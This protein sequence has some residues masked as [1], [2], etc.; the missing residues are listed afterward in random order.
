MSEV[1]VR[2]RQRRVALDPTPQEVASAQAEVKEGF[3][4]V[5]RVAYGQE[6]ETL[7]KV[8][9]PLFGTQSA[10]VRVSAGATR[11]L[12]DYNSARV[13]VMIELPCYPEESEMRRAYEFAST[14]LDELV[15]IELE[16]AGVPVG[17]E[18]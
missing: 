2:Q 5:Q 4:L 9:V 7:E 14:M 12:G 3:V 17:Q 11:N 18:G 10:R 8:Y 6:N 15:P 13:D 1:N 16:K